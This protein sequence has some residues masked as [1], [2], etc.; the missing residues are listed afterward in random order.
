[1]IMISDLISDHECSTLYLATLTATGI[2]FELKLA[3][4]PDSL[5]ILLVII[6]S[7]ETSHLEI[8]QC[9][10]SERLLHML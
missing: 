4:T 8:N 6:L 7:T 3:Q 9:N 1:M 10:V 5:G 2:T